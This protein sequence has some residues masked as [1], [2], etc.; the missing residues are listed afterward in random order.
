MIQPCK[1][2]LTSYIDYAE[3]QTCKKV[4]TKA[5]RNEATSGSIVEDLTKEISRL[6]EQLAAQGDSAG[7]RF[8][9][10]FISF[11]LFSSHL[12]AV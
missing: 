1:P 7:A 9:K 3:A 4:A 11:H 12:K 2:H 10:H 8:L 5:V 6:K